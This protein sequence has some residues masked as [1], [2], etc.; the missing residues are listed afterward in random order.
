MS[1]DF[2]H[3]RSHSGKWRLAFRLLA[4][5]R[6]VKRALVFSQYLFFYALDKLSPE[7]TRERPKFRPEPVGGPSTDNDRTGSIE[8]H[9]ESDENAKREFAQADPARR[10]LVTH[11]ADKFR[12]ATCFICGGALMP[13]IQVL[14]ADDPA[15]HIEI[16]SCR[17][18]DH[19][20]YSVMPSRAWLAHW[21]ATHYD[22][23]LTLAENLE[24]R[25]PSQ[26]YRY[27]LARYIGERKLRVLD[28]GAGYAEKTHAFALAGHELHC[29]EATAPRADYLRRLV[30][31]RVYF[32][33]LA[34]PA[35]AEAVRRNGPYD[36][37]FTYHVVEHMYDARAELQILREVAAEDAIFYLAIPELYKEGILNN[38]YALEHVASFSRR[39]A[40]T[41]MRE[42]G[43]RP[44]LAK[45]DLF[46]NYS[47]NCQYLI[48]R[49]AHAGE[50]GAGEADEKPRDMVDYL[51]RAL[52][53]PRIAGLDSGR[54]S[55]RYVGHDRLSYRISYSSRMKCREPGAHLP[56][57]IYHHGLPLFWMQ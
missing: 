19:L 44:I 54:F 55:Y 35:V 9:L 34:D 24:M 6:L 37:I 39:S 5:G 18:C 10:A 53:L 14:D 1:A 45:D 41:L 46:Q 12:T 32:G 38:I 17:A 57:R 2:A 8:F 42:V 15:D 22:R 13:V 49:K 26:L 48:G 27:R 40:K 21:Y 28:I 56:L 31:D 11:V 30:G 33:T 20:Q 7:R 29:T 36:I 43:F 47:P 16:S 50:T 4:Q 23:S 52:S 25:R 51:R 3:A